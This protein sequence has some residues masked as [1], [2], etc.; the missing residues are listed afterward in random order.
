MEHPMTGNKRQTV[1][2]Q[3]IMDTLQSATTHPTAEQLHAMVAAAHPSI[4]KA[5]VYRNLHQ[6]V[7]Q[8]DALHIAVTNDAAH[9]DGDTRLHHHFVCDHCGAMHD[10]FLQNEK[11]SKEAI[12]A[13]HTPHGHTIDRSSTV[14]Y[15]QCSSCIAAQA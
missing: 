9:Y 1:Q 12:L 14:F 13:G 10:I 3:I 2:K 4:S 15:G 8:G 5:T 6:L 7:Q 11:T